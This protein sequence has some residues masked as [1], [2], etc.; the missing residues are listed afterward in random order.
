VASTASLR[1]ACFEFNRTGKSFTSSLGPPGWTQSEGSSFLRRATR[2][3]LGRPRAA[4]AAARPTTS[5][6]CARRPIASRRSRGAAGVPCCSPGSS[7]RSGKP[8]DTRPSQHGW[9]G[10][11]KAGWTGAALLGSALGP[12]A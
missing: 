12:P 1:S 3:G 5:C 8:R 9:V 2:P 7:R 10:G 4:E 11:D 6:S